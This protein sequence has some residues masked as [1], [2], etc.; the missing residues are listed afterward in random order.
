MGF[1]G[2]TLL[3]AMARIVHFLESP[4]QGRLASVNETLRPCRIRG[5]NRTFTLANK[6]SLQR[7][8]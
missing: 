2:Q 8:V 7:V 6:P 3:R 4:L 5:V 1:A